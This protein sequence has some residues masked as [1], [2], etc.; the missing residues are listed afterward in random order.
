MFAIEIEIPRTV[1]ATSMLIA[2]ALTLIGIGR[3]LT[4]TVRKP[5]EIAPKRIVTALAPA[6]ET[7]TV[8]P[9]RPIVPNEIR[10]PLRGRAAIVRGPMTIHP[11]RRAR[12]PATIRVVTAHH[13]RKPART[14]IRAGAPTRPVQERIP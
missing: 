3:K 13:R 9:R 11:R 8:P 14:Q 10:P 7:A 2:T 5:I 6:R 1:T 12:G 4:V